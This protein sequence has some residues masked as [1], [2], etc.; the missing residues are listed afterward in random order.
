MKYV[1]TAVLKKVIWS[2]MLHQFIRTASDRKSAKIKHDL[3]SFYPYFF[4]KYQS[5]AK[6]NNLNNTEVLSSDF[7]GSYLLCNLNDL[8]GLNNLSGLN[9]LNSLI[10][11]KKYSTW[12]LHHP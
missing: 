8:D 10:S 7:F 12:W 1:T 9:D 5:E 3:S 4:F 2:D 11:S 6:Y